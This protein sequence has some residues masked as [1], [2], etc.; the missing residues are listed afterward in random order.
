VTGA[1]EGD[2]TEPLHLKVPAALEGERVD[3][4][5]AL[6]AGLSRAQASRVVAEGKASVGGTTVVVGSRRL[7]TGELLQ[8]DLSADAGAVPAGGPDLGAD[9][10]PAGGNGAGPARVVF[11]DDNLVVV[12]KPAGLVVHPGAGNPQGTL[13]QQLIALFPDIVNAGPDGDRPGIVHRLDKGTSGLMV[14]ARTAAAREDLVRQMAGRLTKRR[15]LALVHGR[16]EADEGV[17][18]APL[19]RSQSHRVKMAVVQGGRSSRTHYRAYE[20]GGE[21]L[22]AT[23]VVCRLETGRTHQ[24]RV[25]FAAIGHPVVGDDRYSKPSL[26]ALTR[27][28]LPLLDRPWL[29]AA[30][31][32]F[33]HPLSGEVMSFSAPLPADLVGTLAVLGLSAPDVVA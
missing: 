22:P 7:H 23:L 12:D 9:G 4:G 30:Q 20:R 2:G 1:G 27:H 19:G 29:H 33:T 21:P 3:R 18:E 10:Q 13:V 28:E 6:L 14:V 31:L 8:V 26:A 24:V 16:V 11:A 5:L 25:H 17:I 32:G 15:Y